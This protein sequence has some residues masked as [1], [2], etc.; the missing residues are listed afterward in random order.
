MAG[1][2]NTS[3]FILKLIHLPPRLAYAIGLGS[4]IGNVVL[5]LTTRGR[6]SHR[7]RITPLQYEE[8]DGKIYLGSALGQKADWFRNVRANPRVELR[9]KSRHFS[10]LAETVLDTKRIADFLEI[11]FHR[12]PGMIGAMFRA[13]GI[14]IP[15]E[16]C[17]LEKYAANLALVVIKP[18]Q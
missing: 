14:R 18:D 2:N 6:K 7:P 15:P 9:I 11:R 16:R 8:I 3:K 5:L 13:E 4:V 1:F 17:D 10:G 12:H